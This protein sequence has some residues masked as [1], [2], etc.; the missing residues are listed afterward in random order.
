MNAFSASTKVR[1]LGLCTDTSNALL[2]TFNEFLKSLAFS[3]AKIKYY[4]TLELESDRIT[5]KFGVYQQEREK[6]SHLG[7]PNVRVHN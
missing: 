5:G 3:S 1:I 7:P 6:L 2:F 4:L